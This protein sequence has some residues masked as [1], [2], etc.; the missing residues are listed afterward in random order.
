MLRELFNDEIGF[1]S[2]GLRQ[3]HS[4]MPKPTGPDVG[5]SVGG[6][7]GVNVWS[8]GGVSVDLRPT[9]GVPPT[10]GVVTVTIGGSSGGSGNS[11]S[12]NWAAEARELQLQNDA[13]S[14]RSPND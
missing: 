3:D 8:G 1:V 2:G 12:T 7:G 9:G 13:A 10:G 11:G 5:G 6:G 14:G 4:P